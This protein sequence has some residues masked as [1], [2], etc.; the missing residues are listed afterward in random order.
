MNLFETLYWAFFATYV[1]WH[2]HREHKLRLDL[3]EQL[4]AANAERTGGNH[5]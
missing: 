2:W 1:L 4:H 3:E 5:Q